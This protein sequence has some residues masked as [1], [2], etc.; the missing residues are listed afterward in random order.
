MR[1]LADEN[2][3]GGTV[4]ALERNGHDVVWA[5]KDYPGASDKYLSEIAQSE[6]RIILTFDKDF[7]EITFRQ[8]LPITCGIVLFRGRISSLSHFAEFAVQVLESRDDWTGNFALVEWTRIR[9]R[10]LK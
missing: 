9:M 8:K 2:F 4:I 5:R 6:N 3:P 1:F 7:G 10:P